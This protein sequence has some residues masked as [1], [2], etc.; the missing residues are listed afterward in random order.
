MSG[1]T[2]PNGR[3]TPPARNLKSDMLLA[4]TRTFVEAERPDRTTC[5]QFREA[6]YLLIGQADAQT[7]QKVATLVSR[8]AFCPRPIALYLAMEAPTIAMPILRH[9][10]VLGLLDM[11]QVISKRGAVHARLLA[12]RPALPASIVTQMRALD[13]ADVTAALAANRGVQAAARERQ[14]RIAKVAEAKAPPAKAKIEASSKAPADAPADARELERRLMDALG[15]QRAA[16]PGVKPAPKRLDAAAFRTAL[17]TAALSRDR[18]A[19]ARAMR[20]RL[21]LA[22]GTAMQ[23][24]DDHS[25]NALMV[26]MKAEGFAADVAHRVVLMALPTVGLSPQAADRVLRTWQRLEEASC[27][28]ALAQWPRADATRT[29]SQTDGAEGVRREAARTTSVRDEATDLRR[30][31]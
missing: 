19:M 24:L 22:H 29:I 27:R 15:A 31:G 12:A 5:D 17:E 30:A 1:N 25:G 7:R 2:A 21:G 10:P 23:V 20:A 28:A 9:S 8:A 16:R 14:A 18:A 26:L 4:A 3:R 6:F 13:D 11:A